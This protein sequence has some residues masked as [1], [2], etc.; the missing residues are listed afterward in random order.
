[1][2]ELA[3]IKRV[4]YPKSQISILA[5]CLHSPWRGGRERK[6]LGGPPEVSLRLSSTRGLLHRTADFKHCEL[7]SLSLSGFAQED[8]WICSWDWPHWIK[9]ADSHVCIWIQRLRFLKSGDTGRVKSGHRAGPGK[10]GQVHWNPKPRTGC[11]QWK[12]VR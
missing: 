6:R 2:K 1:M 4:G 3:G 5:W 7:S 8:R 11:G 12:R 10:A 9:T